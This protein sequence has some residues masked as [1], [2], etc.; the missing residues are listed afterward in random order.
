MQKRIVMAIPV[1]VIAVAGTLW[2]SLALGQGA[3]PPSLAE[4]LEAQYKLAKIGSDSNGPTVLDAG[5]VLDIQK[6]GIL[7]VPWSSPKGCPAKFENSDLKPPSGWCTQARKHG[8]KHG[9]GLLTS[10]LPGAVADD[11]SDV[12]TN[13]SDT[14]YFQVGDK[15]YPS[16]I[17]VDVKKDKILFG[18]VACDTCNNTNPPTYYKSEVEFEFARGYLAKAGVSAVEDTIG[19]VFSIDSGGDSQQDQGAQ[20]GQ[21]QSQGGQDQTQAQPPAAAAP[22]PAPAQPQSIQLGETPAQVQAALGPAD[23]VVNLG[24]KM[25]WIYKDLKVTFVNGK[26]SDAE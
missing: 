3:A 16:S 12:N 20:G 1:M 19:Q 9:F 23:K 4:Q 2:C 26:V 25:I 11:A 7:G 18:V 8:G 21:D 13:V 10:H 6:G 5:T 15:V 17:S 22:A 24:S 14:K